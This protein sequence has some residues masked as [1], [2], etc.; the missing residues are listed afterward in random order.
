MLN[1]DRL[2]AIMYALVLVSINM[3]TKFEVPSFTRSKDINGA[4]KFKNR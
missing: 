2:T 4:Q 1:T 3:H